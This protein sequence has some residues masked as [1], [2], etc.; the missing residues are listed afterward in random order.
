[1]R[2]LKGLIITILVA[3]SIAAQN[4]GGAKPPDLPKLVTATE[5]QSLRFRNSL[6]EI[7]N[8]RLQAESATARAN[9]LQGTLPEQ[10]AVIA[11]E[12]KIDLTKYEVM[13]SV[14][15]AYITDEK[16]LLQFSIKETK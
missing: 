3:L 5:S 16:G 15:G 11:K 4:G 10:I 14:N 1:M 2:I 7:Q 6:L 9:L 8:L 13:R 12:N